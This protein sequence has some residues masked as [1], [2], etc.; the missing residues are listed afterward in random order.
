MCGDALYQAAHIDVVHDHKWRSVVLRVLG[1][2]QFCRDDV[3]GAIG[4]DINL[5]SL[6]SLAGLW[7]II[8]GWRGWIAL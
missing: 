6:S 8:L 5:S 7:I 4:G 1:A 2:V 3:D